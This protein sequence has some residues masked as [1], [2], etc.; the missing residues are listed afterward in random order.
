MIEPQQSM[1]RIHL[2]TKLLR[3]IRVLQGCIVIL[4]FAV[5]LL[6]INTFYPLI[7]IQHF[8]AIDAQQINILGKNG[9][10]KAKLSNAAGF[11]HGYRASHDVPMFSG[12]MFYNEEGEETGGLIYHGHAIPGGQD[13]DVSLTMDQYHQDQNVYLNHT[14]HV[15]AKER[16]ISDGLQINSRPDWTKIKQEYAIYAQMEKLPPDQ[17]KALARQ[18]L[19]NGQ[20]STRR[21]FIGARRG[22]KENVPYDNTGLFIKNRLGQDAIKLYVDY[23]NTPHLEFYDSSGKLMDYKLGPAK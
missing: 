16:L 12:L 9:I 17:Q 3:Q 1:G 15:D 20:I 14:E 4:L 2:E 11:H 23:N 5:A 13:S 8:R 19:R 6:W 10:L 7:P 18:A 22:D 21:L